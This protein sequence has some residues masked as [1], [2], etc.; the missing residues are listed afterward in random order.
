MERVMKSA[1][2]FAVLCALC[3][4]LVGRAQ[5][6]PTT[7]PADQ[8]AEDVLNRMLKPATQAPAP[9]QPVASPPAVDK[10]SGP[11]AV[12]PAAPQMRLIREGSFIVDKTG[13]LSKSA[14]GQQA[15]ITFDSDRQAMQ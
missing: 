2:G 9:L 7:R 12:A 4:A 6:A 14:D 1:A 11:N 10:N 8:P 5:T 3:F 15:E 13:R